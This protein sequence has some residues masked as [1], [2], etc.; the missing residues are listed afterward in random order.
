MIQPFKAESHWAWVCR[1][2]GQVLF[3]P[4]LRD[5]AK[6]CMAGGDFWWCIIVYKKCNILSRKKNNISQSYC[7]FLRDL[8]GEILQDL[9]GVS[10][11]KPSDGVSGSRTHLILN[12]L[13]LS[14]TFRAGNPSINSSF[15]IAMLSCTA[16]K[17]SR[18]ISH[19][20][21]C[22]ALTHGS[23]R[24]IRWPCSAG[25]QKLPLCSLCW[26]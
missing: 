18:Q 10:M 17:A 4:Q 12:P 16:I 2:F 22:S 26:K 13:D 23:L 5:A 3:C 21:V 20:F 19:A 7:S 24:E 6:L 11:P 1:R 8:T 25:S 9:T 15:G 14:E